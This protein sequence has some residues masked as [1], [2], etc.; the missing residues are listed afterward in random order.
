MSYEY[1]W[2]I[3]LI[4]LIVVFWF[5]FWLGK[6]KLARQAIIPRF[7]VT[8]GR[9]KSGTFKW[10]IVNIN[11]TAKTVAFQP[12]SGFKSRELAVAD[13]ESKFAGLTDITIMD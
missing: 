10:K 11:N 6:R 3:I 8:F 1:L 4:K 13:A 12:G 7:A 9:L 5:G 2:I